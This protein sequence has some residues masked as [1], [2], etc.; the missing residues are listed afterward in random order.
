MKKKL[1]AAHFHVWKQPNIDK[2][3]AVHAKCAVADGEV[4][5][6]TSAN[7][8]GKAMNE[9]MELGILINGGPVPKQLS[10]HLYALV[11]EKIII[12]I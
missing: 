2:T 11:T 9:N 12:E 1:P 5:M 8:T 6:I 7:L 3:A 10:D 4:A